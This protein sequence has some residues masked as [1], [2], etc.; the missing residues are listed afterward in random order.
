MYSNSNNVW[1]RLS[2]FDCSG[3]PR[4]TRSSTRLVWVIMAAAAA[5][6]EA[7]GKKS[8]RTRL[9]GPSTPW[10]G[11]SGRTRETDFGSR[12]EAS[13]KSTTTE[14]RYRSYCD[15]DGCQMDG[16][17]GEGKGRDTTNHGKDVN[18]Q[19]DKEGIFCYIPGNVSFKPYNR[20][21]SKHVLATTLNVLLRSH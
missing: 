2:G 18:I 13:P 15:I 7:D 9:R 12:W 1:I 4:V 21:S 5:V 19:Y 11:V 16:W 3:D 8:T 14:F 10:G 6:A 20:K 17:G